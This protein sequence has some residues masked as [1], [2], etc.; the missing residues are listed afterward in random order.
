[1][2]I[3]TKHVKISN[4]KF[5]SH[6]YIRSFIF[7][8]TNFFNV[9]IFFCSPKN[10]FIRITKDENFSHDKHYLT[11]TPAIAD[12]VCSYDLDQ[13]DEAWLKE[14]NGERSLCGLPPVN[15]EQFERIVEELEVN[16]YK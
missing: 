12:S 14:F 3:T 7:N 4:C 8:S 2:K 1:M 10:K 13:L 9:S 5:S 11:N 16:K 15:E 6:T